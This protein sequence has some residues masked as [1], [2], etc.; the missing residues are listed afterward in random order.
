[1]DRFFKSAFAQRVTQGFRAP[2]SAIAGKLE[3]C[4]RRIFRCVFI[5]A[6]SALSPL[7]PAAGGAQNT[8]Q[9]EGF[10]RALNSRRSDLDRFFYI[11]NF[12]LDHREDPGQIYRQFLAFSE[13]ELGL[14]ME[15][16]RDFPVKNAL[17]PGLVIPSPDQWEPEEASEAIASLARNR[18]IVM[19][20]EAHH[21]AQT[22]ILTIKLLPKLRELGFRYF[23]VEALKDIASDMR[24]RGYPR[25][26]DGSEYIHEPLYG[27]MLREAI[28]LGYVIVPYE[29]HTSDTQGREREQ[30][31][32]IFRRTFKIDRSAKVFVHAGYAHIDKKV[33]RLGAAHPMAMELAGLTRLEPLTVDQTDIREDLPS[34]EISSLNLGNNQI[35]LGK[36][37]R[38]P[39]FV[40]LLRMHSKPAVDAYHQIIDNFHPQ[41]GVVLRSRENGRYWSARP[42]VYDLSVISPPANTM[43]TNYDQG[44]ISV[45]YKD[46]QILILP[47]ANGGKRPAYLSLGGQR[48]AVPISADDCS[49]QVPCLI[50]AFSPAQSEDAIPYDRYLIIFKQ[51]K[52]ELYLRA[53]TYRIVASGDKGVVETK[54]INV[55]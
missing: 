40:S 26:S 36:L 39:A 49:H 25:Q 44:S 54:L 15:A 14:Y 1:M 9:E 31:D 21:D 23:A 51:Q 30:A 42:G 47:P 38:D 35:K 20:N 27:E 55:E 12:L 22:R 29:A 28:R 10:L 11:N 37:D 52:S 13:C 18:S 34:L 2:I 16:I 45:R 41:R 48:K 4:M 24:K 6:L 46:R 32:N 17:P 53:G 5:S 7:S 43:P 8:G 19:V 50:E 3:E 33:S